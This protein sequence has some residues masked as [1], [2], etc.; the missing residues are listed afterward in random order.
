MKISCVPLRYDC[1]DGNSFSKFHGKTL[2]LK[3]LLL[4]K[5]DK[6]IVTVGNPNTQVIVQY[7]S[8]NDILRIFFYVESS[9]HCP[10]AFS[11]SWVAFIRF[12]KSMTL[13]QPQ[14]SMDL[15]RKQVVLHARLPLI[16]LARS[17]SQTNLSRLQMLKQHVL[18][19]R[20]KARKTTEEGRRKRQDRKRE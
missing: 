6:N 13:K 16:P 11:T 18:Q 5:I 1:T 8:P 17:T 20:K 14:W 12:F 3:C 2:F 10:E 15:I 9:H 4:A 19:S 7:W